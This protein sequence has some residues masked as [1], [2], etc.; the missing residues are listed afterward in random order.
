MNFKDFDRVHCLCGGCDSRVTE[1]HRHIPLNYPAV[2]ATALA[3][4][5][6][7]WEAKCSG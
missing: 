6:W 3:A 7:G 5:C 4:V 2:A 1:K